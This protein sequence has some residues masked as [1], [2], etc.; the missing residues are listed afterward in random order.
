MLQ[1]LLPAMP[2]GSS[3]WPYLDAR[4]SPAAEDYPRNWQDLPVDPSIPDIASWS[5]ARMSQ[6]LVQNG[7]KDTVAKVFF[8]QVWDEHYLK[9]GNK[10]LF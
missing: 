1:E 7:I 3:P 10:K 9:R 6:Y 5:A 8:D 4:I 2:P